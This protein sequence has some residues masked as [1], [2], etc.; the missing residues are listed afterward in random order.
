[1]PQSINPFN[2]KSSIRFLLGVALQSLL[3]LVRKPERICDAVAGA[4]KGAVMNIIAAPPWFTEV[5][6][7]NERSTGPVNLD[8][9]ASQAED[10]P[11][12]GKVV[13]FPE[14]SCAQCAFIAGPGCAE[15]PQQVLPRLKPATPYAGFSF[16]PRALLQWRVRK[17]YKI[18]TAAQGLGVAASTW[19]H[20]ETGFRFPTG[21]VLLNL[22]QYTG[23]SLAELICEHGEQCPLHS[24]LKAGIP[25]LSTV[26]ED[27]KD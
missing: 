26:S 10:S 1:M 16:L 20:W 11:G 12:A 22:V 13:F 8:P 24:H 15:D 3:G 18:S 9:E 7:M 2:L 6:G 25:S 21:S 14:G 5:P 4:G 19:G 27:K 23:L 17:G